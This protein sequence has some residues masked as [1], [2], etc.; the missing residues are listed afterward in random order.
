M[1]R[2][3]NIVTRT[4]SKQQKIH[5]TEY[6]EEQASKKVRKKEPLKK[7]VNNLKKVK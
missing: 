7:Y 3:R 6:R 2:V 4:V 1:G 5:K